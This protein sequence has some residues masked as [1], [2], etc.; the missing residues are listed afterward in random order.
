MAQKRESMASQ[1][2]SRALDKT[3]RA[4]RA[5]GLRT[6][7]YV[8]SSFD[9]SWKP[10]EEMWSPSSDAPSEAPLKVTPIKDKTPKLPPADKGKRAYLFMLSAFIIEAIMWGEFIYF[11][12]KLPSPFFAALC[13]A[14]LHNILLLDTPEVD[15]QIPKSLFVIFFSSICICAS[16]SFR[17]FSDGSGFDLEL[18][19]MAYAGFAAVPVTGDMNRDIIRIA[20]LRTSAGIP[21]TSSGVFTSFYN[22]QPG[23]KHDRYIAVIGTLGTVSFCTRTHISKSQPCSQPCLTEIFLCNFLTRVSG[24]TI[25]GCTSHHSTYLEI[26]QISATYDMGRLAHLLTFT[27]C[28]KLL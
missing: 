22:N 3:D 20:N 7:I 2:L 27:H 23:F 24:H 17:S 25:L 14:P 28:C 1:R 10:Q 18:S 8:G 19:C 13:S 16:G 4:S 12:I 5:I 15:T 26:P 6:S 9:L 21:L 11:Y